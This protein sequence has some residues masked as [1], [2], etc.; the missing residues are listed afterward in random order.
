MLETV[1]ELGYSGIELGPPGYFGDDASEV[2]GT[3]APYGLELVGAFAPLR[4]ADEDGFR[5]DLA[6]LDRTIDVLAATGARGPVVLAADESESRL[7]AAG[8]PD[9]AREAGLPRDELRRAAERAER[10]ARRVL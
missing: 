2:A 3:L 4:I 7:A 6:F 5:D 1:R 10:A 9:A 8:R